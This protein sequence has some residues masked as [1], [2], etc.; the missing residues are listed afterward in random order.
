MRSVRKV[1]SPAVRPK[2]RGRCRSKTLK[3]KQCKNPGRVGYAC[4][5][6]M[7]RIIQRINEDLRFGRQNY[8]E[9]IRVL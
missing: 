4:A 8:P 7:G 5:L 3:G 1:L 9:E 2:S 6:H